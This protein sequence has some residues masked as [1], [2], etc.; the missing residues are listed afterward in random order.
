MIN[1]WIG[2]LAGLGMGCG[3]AFG[4]VPNGGGGL[5]PNAAPPAKYPVGTSA[6]RLCLLGDSM[7]SQ[8]D[9]IVS[10]NYTAGSLGGP[11]TWLNLYTDFRAWRSPQTNN[12]AVSGLTLAQVAATVP[13]AIAAGCNIV[14]TEGGSN[15]VASN[16]TCA[17]MNATLASMFNQ[18]LAAGI[19]IIDT[20]IIPRS[21]G[22]IFTASQIAVTL[23]SNQWRRE[24]ARGFSPNQSAG[25]YLA[26]LDPIFV[27]PTST[28]WAV[29][30][31]YLYD[32]VHPSAI[33]S[34][35]WAAAVA[36]FINALIP[37]WLLP[38]P[39]NCTTG[40]ICSDIWDAT[41]NPR[42]NLL[43][44]P[45]LA[46][47]AGA[48]TGCSGTFA[49][50]I[51][52][53][54]STFAAN[55]GTCVG[56]IVTLSNNVRAQQIVVGGTL[57]PAA[58]F[59]V[60]ISV[61]TPS[62]VITGDTVRAILWVS[63]GATNTNIQYLDHFMQ[64]T[65]S[66]LAT[67]HHAFGNSAPFPIPTSGFALGVVY[68]GLTWV[69]MVT[70]SFTVTAAPTQLFSDFRIG[71]GSTGAIASTIQFIAPEIRKVSP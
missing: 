52:G 50:G 55:G 63:L 27:D 61:A 57:S 28:T 10:P 9:Q 40:P 68:G 34:S 71:S 58:Q 21:G 31:N 64:L 13:S 56:S 33:G 36:P 53:S 4:Q 59:D 66:G 67:F 51:G 48:I 6:K 26:D 42:G 22:S 18:L 7:I 60:Q 70:D 14:H 1:K 15:D 45:A 69:P 19:T 65:V 47:T 29:L 3:L 24:F 39:S 49:T 54:A 35:A 12:F 17:A 37:A 46:G 16:A 44:N 43:S 5:V 25:Y 38:E 30:A 32:N 62:N 20:T 8:S 11:G 23:C 2:V 41:N